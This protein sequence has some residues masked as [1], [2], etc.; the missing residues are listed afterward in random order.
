MSYKLGYNLLIHFII[1]Y[2]SSIIL[3]TRRKG[4]CNETTVQCFYERPHFKRLNFERERSCYH[5]F[6]LFVT[7]LSF[8]SF[9]GNEEGNQPDKTSTGQQSRRRKQREW[10]KA[11]GLLSENNMPTHVRF[12]FCYISWPFPTKQQLQMIKLQ[13]SWRT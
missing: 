6:I 1:I 7:S 2:L 3:L 4:V 13:V 12:T 8:F 9:D 11:I 5:S 10:Y